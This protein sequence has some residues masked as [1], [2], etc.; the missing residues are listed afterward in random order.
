M[1]ALAGR[2]VSLDVSSNQAVGA[3]RGLAAMLASG[4]G[5]PSI[6]ARDC[7]LGDAGVARIMSA[8]ANCLDLK[9]LDI[10]CNIISD[11]GQLTASF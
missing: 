9:A 3:P 11:P 1:L 7:G 8:A 6:T 5:V 4:T 10:S 2:N